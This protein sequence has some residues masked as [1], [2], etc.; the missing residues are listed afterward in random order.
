MRVKKILLE[1]QSFGI[2]SDGGNDRIRMNLFDVF[3]SLF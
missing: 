1:N 3:K 2:S